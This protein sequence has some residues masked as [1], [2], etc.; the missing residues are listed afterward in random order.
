VVSTLTAYAGVKGTRSRL[1]KSCSIRLVPPA[2]K[3]FASLSFRSASRGI[4][5]RPAGQYRAFALTG[6]IVGE[7][8]SPPST[9]SDVPFLYAGQ[10]YDIALVWVAVLVLSTLALSCTSR[11]RGRKALLR[12]GARQ[13]NLQVN[14]LRSSESEDDME[15]GEIS[16]ES[17]RIASA[18]RW[19][20]RQ[21]SGR[22]SA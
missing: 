1:A 15:P 16:W 14:Q 4:I 20:H 12:K 18:L 13:Y 6:A 21:P 10:T 5:F 9:D 19:R 8:Q 7:F 17:N 11:S 2:R 22:G 3:C